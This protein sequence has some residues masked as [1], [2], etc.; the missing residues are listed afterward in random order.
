MTINIRIK[1][2]GVYRKLFGRALI[3]IQLD[4]PITVGAMIQ[5]I[6]DS[7][8]KGLKEELIDPELNNPQLNALIMIDGKEISVLSG[9]ETKLDKDGEIVI[10]PVSHGG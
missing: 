9:L 2:V 10:I 1:P 4:E 8:L 5:R 3:E 7:H 6:A